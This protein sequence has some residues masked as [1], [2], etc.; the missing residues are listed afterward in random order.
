[1]KALELFVYA[2]LLTLTSIIWVPA[3]T[4]IGVGGAGVFLLLHAITGSSLVACL[5]SGLSGVLE[6]HVLFKYL[7]PLVGREQGVFKDTYT[8]YLGFAVGSPLASLV[9]QLYVLPHFADSLAA[10]LVAFAVAAFA[11]GFV[12]FLV[13]GLLGALGLPIKLPAR[14]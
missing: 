9:A 2:L 7:I 13:T 8:F 11:T 6:V 14:R 10:P 1:M 5:G 4:F 12:P 3:L